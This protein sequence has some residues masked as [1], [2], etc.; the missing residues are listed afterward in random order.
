MPRNKLH[1]LTCLPADIKTK[2]ATFLT[3]RDAFRLAMTCKKVQ[4]DL[5]LSALNPAFELFED[6]AW[7]G[8]R[9]ETVNPVCGPEIPVV[10]RQQ[11]HS[12]T[13][14][15]KLF[16]WGQGKL[17]ILGHTP[18]GDTEPEFPSGRRVASS[19]LAEGPARIFKASFHPRS[20]ETYNLWIL[21]GGCA[22]HLI[23]VFGANVTTVVH[24]DRKRALLN[25]YE[26]VCFGG[27][28]E[29]AGFPKA[30]YFCPSLLQCV[31]ESLLHQLSSGEEPDTRLKCF[32][33]NMSH[34]G[35]AN[36]TSLVALSELARFFASYRP[37]RQTEY[38]YISWDDESNRTVDENSDA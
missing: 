15:C 32:L 3:A 6:K 16:G 36:E 21:V 38:R 13:F 25:A 7:H 2:V 5:A 34:L 35:E 37:D 23:H 24:G 12:I 9:T 27:L 11:V 14:E 8:H 28:F 22:D 18:S 26:C 30:D 33:E 20:D 19:P 4:K 1:H 17:Y 31:C 10:F 29:T